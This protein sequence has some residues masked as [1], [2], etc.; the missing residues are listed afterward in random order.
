MVW[1]MRRPVIG[2]CT[3]LER[4][5]WSVWDQ[6]AALLPVNYIEAVQ[7]AG[8]LVADAPAGPGCWSSDPQ[9]AL[10]LIDGLMLAGGADIDPASYEQE[11]HPETVGTVPERDAS[12]SRSP[13]R[14]SSATCPCWASAAA[15][16]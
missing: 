4:A 7:R 3:A 5:S 9:Q 2:I 14:R 10:E 15:C 12:R 1:G 6:P 8:G 13:A 11:P 16:S